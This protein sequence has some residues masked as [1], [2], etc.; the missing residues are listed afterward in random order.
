MIQGSTIIFNDEYISEINRHINNTEQKLKCE[1]IPNER[2]KLEEHLNYLQTKL[3][4][5]MDFQDTVSELINVDI[6]RIAAVKT[7]SGIVLPLRN[8]Q[9]L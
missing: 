3:D 8:V 9:V 1:V 6:P 7:V 4:E 2:Q 5:A